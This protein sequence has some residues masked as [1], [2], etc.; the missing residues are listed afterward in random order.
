MSR[1][2]T[3]IA[4]LVAALLIVAIGVW[5]LG[6]QTTACMGVYPS[7]GQPPPIRYIECTGGAPNPTEC[8]PFPPATQ[9]IDTRRSP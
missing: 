2:A 5:T 3:A 7:C 6:T 4:V 1:Y 8:P 9:L